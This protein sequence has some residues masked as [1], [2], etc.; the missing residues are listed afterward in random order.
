MLL[1]Q[2]AESQAEL[3]RVTFLFYLSEIPS[4][5]FYVQHG[6][7][8]SWSALGDSVM[9]HVGPHLGMK[10]SVPQLLAS[11]LCK[12]F[13][14]RKLPHLKSGLLWREAVPT[15]WSWWVLKGFVYLREVGRVVPTPELPQMLLKPV[16]GGVPQL[17]LSAQFC[18]SLPST[19][20]H[21]KSTQ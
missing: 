15:N 13:L 17:S 5:S 14:L 20:G 10:G 12:M 2:G 1:L 11:I 19:M 9:H 4:F 16:L 7:P 8:A 21:P 18:V 3:W 6:V